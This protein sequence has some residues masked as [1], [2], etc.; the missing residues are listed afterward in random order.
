[1]SLKLGGL[2]PWSS[3]DYPGHQ[4]AVL[5]CSGCPWRCR[6]CHNSHLWA[7]TA[8][9]S[10][11]AVRV[12]LSKRRGLLDAVVISGGEPLQQAAAVREAFI[13]IR[14]MGFGRALHTA[15]VSARRLEGLLAHC[16]WIGL[17]VKA[18]FARY[19]AI[20][21]RTGSG[22]QARACV[23]LVLHSGIAHE[24]RATVHPALLPEPALVALVTD[25]ALMGV[26][27]LTLRDFRPT[28]CPDPA[29]AHSYRPWLTPDLE[30]RLRAILPGIVL[31]A[32]A[33]DAL[34]SH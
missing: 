2:V 33:L 8:S 28:G 3:V 1:M 19:P 34:T 11:D 15:G 25:L 6:Y 29:L 30:R 32:H 4:A 31:P 20:T 5:F 18:P 23:D 22:A 21:G 7:R 27:R 24:L 16:D 9:P 17:D 12:F 13:E 10:W 26:T 14:D